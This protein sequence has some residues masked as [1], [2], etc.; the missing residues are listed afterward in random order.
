METAIPVVKFIA[1]KV[2]RYVVAALVE[3]RVDRGLI[4]IYRIPTA[5]VH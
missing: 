3:G 2:L 4:R 5:A 1:V